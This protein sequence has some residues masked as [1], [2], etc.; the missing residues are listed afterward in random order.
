MP[1]YT[2]DEY[3]RRVEITGG[4]VQQPPAAP[5]LAVPKETLYQRF[6]APIVKSGLATLR[7][8]MPGVSHALG[9]LSIL[10]AIRRAR[11][12][13]PM[14]EPIATKYLGPSGA[15]VFKPTSPSDVFD[16]LAPLNL[17]SA[18]PIFSAE[19]IHSYRTRKPVDVSDVWQRMLYPS[20]YGE[21]R[22]LSSELA[23]AA[24][25]NINTRYPTVN[26]IGVG[27]AGLIGTAGDIG[28]SFDVLLG[29]LL[30]F[31]GQVTR[32][33]AIGGTP[34]AVGQAFKTAVDQGLLERGSATARAARSVASDIIDSIRAFHTT[35]VAE[36]M[37]MPGRK[38]G[39][40]AFNPEDLS[41]GGA[42]LQRDAETGLV[43]STLEPWTA[44]VSGSIRRNLP[45]VG[46]DELGRLTN[47][48]LSYLQHE[49]S[50]GL[51]WRR[52]GNPFAPLTRAGKPILDVPVEFREEW[53][54]RERDLGRVLQR[55][56]VARKI[57]GDVPYGT[58][59]ASL[60]RHLDGQRNALTGLVDRSRQEIDALQGR[61]QELEQGV[62]DWRQQLSAPF[63]QAHR[64]WQQANGLLMR[65]LRDLRRVTERSGGPVP[66]I[67]DI[68]EN[69]IEP[70]RRQWD[71]AYR[72]LMETVAGA[73]EQ[74]RVPL[75]LDLPVGTDADS[76]PE[77]QRL[78][79]RSQ[80]LF[81]QEMKPALEARLAELRQ[82]GDAV[83]ADE[84]DEISKLLQERRPSR[85][86]VTAP[87]R[88]EEYR[89]WSELRR[90]LPAEAYQHE[91]E[92]FAGTWTD[93]D[94][95]WRLSSPEALYELYWLHQRPGG[96]QAAD[97]EK[98]FKQWR[99]RH[100]LSSP[101]MDN[102]ARQAVQFVEE[103]GYNLLDPNS[104]R[105]ETTAA[106]NSYRRWLED[107]A[108]YLQEDVGAIRARED[109]EQAVNAYAEKEAQRD[110]VLRELRLT[111][112]E[113][114]ADPAEVERL[115]KNVAEAY[116]DELTDLQR[117][118]RE[119]EGYLDPED[120]LDEE[121]KSVAERATRRAQRRAAMQSMT[122][123]TSLDDLNYYNSKIRRAHDL[124]YNRALD[125][126][127]N[128]MRT[129]KAELDNLYD[130]VRA[131]YRQLDEATAAARATQSEQ[132]E[133][134]RAQAQRV[135]QAV[136]AKYEAAARK[137]ER[138][139]ERTAILAQQAAVIK[140][141]P[142]RISDADALL[143]KL[144][145]RG[146]TITPRIEQVIRQR[147]VRHLEKQIAT[148]TEKLQTLPEEQLQELYH[149]VWLEAMQRGAY[150]RLPKGLRA[151][152]RGIKGY[153]SSQAHMKPVHRNFWRSRLSTIG[154]REV[155]R[156]R[157]ANEIFERRDIQYSEGIAATLQHIHSEPHYYKAAI[158]EAPAGTQITALPLEERLRMVYQ[159]LAASDRTVKPLADYSRLINPDGTLN[160][161]LVHPRVLAVFDA[162][163]EVK[164]LLD[165]IWH[166][167]PE[168]EWTSLRDIA[169]KVQ[170]RMM[171]E[172]APPVGDLGPG[173]VMF[174]APRASREEL[175]LTMEGYLTVGQYF[176]GPGRSIW[177]L[178]ATAA[179]HEDVV[180]DKAR[181]IAEAVN[182]DDFN[183]E[184]IL[185]Q[186]DL[187]ELDLQ[188]LVY[189]YIHRAA[190]M[191]R[192][193][194]VM[195]MVE[196]YGIHVPS[197][198][199]QEALRY[200]RAGYVQ[201]RWS[202]GKLIEGLSNYLIPPE[203]QAEIIDRAPAIGDL[204]R[205]FLFLNKFASPL[206]GPVLASLENLTN[207]LKMNV[208]E[209]FFNLLTAVGFNPVYGRHM[210]KALGATTWVM[211]QHHAEVARYGATHLRPLSSTWVTDKIREL[212]GYIVSRPSR[213]RQAYE[214]ALRF[215]KQYPVD[216][217][218]G[219]TLARSAFRHFET[220]Q[221][222]R[223]HGLEW[224]RIFNVPKQELKGWLRTY[225]NAAFGIDTVS[226]TALFLGFIEAGEDPATARAL[227][228]NYAVEYSPEMA[229]GVD[230][231]AG[232]LLWFVRYFRH[233]SEQAVQL[234]IRSPGVFGAYT[235]GARRLKSALTHS[236]QQQD[237][238]YEGRPAKMR[239]D[240]GW[241]P[242]SFRTRMKEFRWENYPAVAELDG[243]WTMFERFRIP[244][245]D[246]IGD[247]GNWIFNTSRKLVSSL[248]PPLPAVA[249]ALATHEIDQLPRGIP[250]LGTYVS[251][252]ELL[253]EA[254]DDPKSGLPP[255]QPG[256]LEKARLSKTRWQKL[257]KEGRE[258]LGYAYE[259]QKSEMIR[260]V[261]EYRL[262][263][264][265]HVEPVFW[266][267]C[268]QNMTKEQLEALVR[269]SER[270]GKG[271]Y[272]DGK[273]LEAEL[274]ERQAGR[275]PKTYWDQM[276][277]ARDRNWLN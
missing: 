266:N 57:I 33:W 48:T 95:I 110:D 58:M 24:F 242:V 32:R 167:N 83:F 70:L 29:R 139:M 80:L 176:P 25:N 61:L 105:P 44:L 116:D 23:D 263:Y 16:A 182:E 94:R 96:T 169:N 273:L 194:A 188:Q 275:G 21:P 219:P 274:K 197:I 230:R 126:H 93:W 46:D 226:R 173:Y 177:D 231:A 55:E 47:L 236:D 190:N 189:N 259:Q 224:A 148:A 115:L 54:A 196:R 50:Q 170:R 130:E 4:T 11:G 255:P 100:G 206:K 161:K 45:H 250:V 109:Y 66:A 229:T 5:K 235:A 90:E 154:R 98:L 17:L 27:L 184:E 71:D 159:S 185:R 112:Q 164:V 225:F 84:I 20:E 166:G 102:I 63:Q 114:N 74:A 113:E 119:I 43:R 187:P 142:R 228:T 214:E 52:W 265:R 133:A 65:E 97:Y 85:R 151:V 152:G 268:L 30:S 8:F 156:L 165:Q 183:W 150:E 34:R 131:A 73:P 19:L 42:V 121:I 258:D 135:Y 12:Q 104:T 1:Y 223:R 122:V 203:M 233:R 198:S 244:A 78:I 216:V 246:L 207:W 26:A 49:Y 186:M 88:P 272:V 108:E 10:D 2:F 238:I 175:E 249:N 59:D 195:D 178:T 204:E 192:L 101:S 134:L 13:E 22:W 157:I 92:V 202:T 180:F 276:S 56:G 209:G 217:G 155:E 99:R 86:A 40:F 191:E 221:A 277:P 267:R 213:W 149:N 107:R 239:R 143:A 123:K 18:I 117:G 62:A 39:I 60:Q 106:V 77:L 129:A 35:D 14:F 253:K 240:P 201:P 127:V 158:G 215:A 241:M 212:V 248:V 81:R 145:E 160:R 91:R 168:L 38:T 193:E 163:E 141:L 172:N 271:L 262:K 3:G 199:H 140:R 232:M 179:S 138:R 205:K 220:A 153:V 218:M 243:Y 36:V 256:T 128:T 82:G 171:G 227:V 252:W 120:V 247:W 6:G 37:D 7:C 144:Q 162:G 245:F 146:V 28:L 237:I 200:V 76:V 111:A 41:H 69:R 208:M 234:A 118:I 210:L 64:Q 132:A 136:V 260:K 103:H 9:G 269:T 270:E 124:L 79:R 51:R 67:T 254:V 89:T 125:V 264:G 87:V 251:K 174:T 137:F 68:F 72:S 53:L 222:Y 261:Y 147:A 15:D 257:I 75:G 211:A 31:G 181:R